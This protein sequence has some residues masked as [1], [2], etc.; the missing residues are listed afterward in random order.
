VDPAGRI[1]GYY[2][3]TDPEKV[4]ELMRDIPVLL[5]EFRPQ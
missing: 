3:G 1:R 5:H 2:D 4:D